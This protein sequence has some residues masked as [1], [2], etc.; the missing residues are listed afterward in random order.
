MGNLLKDKKIL[1]KRMKLLK[2]KMDKD[3]KAEFKGAIEEV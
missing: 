3:E 1:S 2:E